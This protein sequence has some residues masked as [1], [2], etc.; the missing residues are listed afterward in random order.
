MDFGDPL[1][2]DGVLV[3]FSLVGELYDD[4][5]LHAL[6]SFLLGKFYW[7]TCAELGW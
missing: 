3:I 4:N 5:E 1:C 2:L 7:G 6:T